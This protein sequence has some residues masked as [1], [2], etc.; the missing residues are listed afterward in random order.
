MIL[1]T[2]SVTNSEVWHLTK[3]K[4]KT[5]NFSQTRNSSSHIG[6][7]CLSDN[8]YIQVDHLHE[9]ECENHLENHGKV[10]QEHE[11]EIEADLKTSKLL[12][13]APVVEGCDQNYNHLKLSSVKKKSF[14]FCFF[15]S[16]KTNTPSDIQWQI[17]ARSIIHI[18]VTAIIHFS[19]PPGTEIDPTNKSKWHIISTIFSKNHITSTVFYKKSKLT[20]THAQYSTAFSILTTASKMARP[21]I[22]SVLCSSSSTAG[23]QTL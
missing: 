18:Q 9:N 11:S 17:I 14:V 22:H 15:P 8:P 3:T 16:K 20:R 4:N 2:I 21:S 1:W 12:L 13:F 6:C 19:L 23:N 7:R 5:D 10:G